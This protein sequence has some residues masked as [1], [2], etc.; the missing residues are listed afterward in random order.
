M[1]PKTSRIAA[2]VATVSTVASLACRS[3]AVGDGQDIIVPFTNWTV[4][5]SI[6]AKKL[7]QAIVLPSGSTFN[8]SADL[9]SGAVTGTIDVPAFTAR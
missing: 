1:S 3:G 6:T 8:G 4:S 7:N 2:L 5:G 9:T